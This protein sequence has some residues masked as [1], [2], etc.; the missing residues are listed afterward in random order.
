MSVWYGGSTKYSAV[1]QWAAST[2]YSVGAIRRQLATPT[3]NNERCFL[4]VVAGTSGGSE[5]A[6][7]ITQGAR[8]TDNSVTWQEVTGKSAVNGDATNTDP[9][10]ASTAV[11]IG[12]IVKNVAGTHY[13]IANNAGT[14][15]SGS[16]PTWST[17]TGATTTDNTITW[18]CIGAVGDYA[19]YAAPFARFALAGMSGRFPA[20]EDTTY[21]SHAHAE[22]WTGALP[23]SSATAGNIICVND[24]VV[25][26][27]TLAYTASITTSGANGISIA[28][29][30]IQGFVFNIGSGANSA[31]FSTGGSG[32]ARVRKCQINI[33]GTSGGNLTMAGGT[34]GDTELDECDITFASTASAIVFQG[35]KC[36]IFGGTIC[37]TGT[38]PTNL[39]N[40][41]ACYARIVGADLSGVSTRL[42]SASAN[43]AC[44]IRF[45]NC[46]LNASV[47]FMTQPTG[48]LNTTTLRV[49]NCDNADTNYNYYFVST[50]AIAQDETSIVRSGGASDGTTA[51]SYSVAGSA[52]CSPRTPYVSEEIAFWNEATGSSKT[53]TIELTT[54]TVLTAAECWMTIEYMGDANSPLT[55]FASSRVPVN[56]SALT[57]SSATWGGT[58]QT[59]KYKIDVNF[60]P[61]NKGPVK[62]RFFLAK[63][64]AT[65][66]F[67]PYITVS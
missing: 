60:T 64:S 46:K 20:Q 62:A 23:S 33:A 63:P 55:S 51:L 11:V 58:A 43:P 41:T 12:A 30:Y 50:S 66:Y 16:E 53:A 40:G 39:A 3:E 61:Q 34:G 26:P 38:V 27:T 25:P 36:N 19:A 32:G 65:V 48:G 35:Y 22:S 13:F 7:T 59:Y 54:N 18:T 47:A 52:R 2:A 56:A 9:W 42:V 29:G 44:E 28:S 57:T 1:T 49:H 24:A 17:T 14:T 45:E 6:W 10:T 21:F 31:N 5:P 67:D 4:C 15:K 8:T 37:A